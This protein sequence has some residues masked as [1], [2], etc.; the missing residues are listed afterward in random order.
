M[1]AG[2]MSIDG[3]QVMKIF[4]EDKRLNISAAYLRPGFAFGG[5][6][7]PKDLRALN[8]LGRKLD[9][10][11]PVLNHILE[12]N[13]TLI[14][15]GV[16]RILKQAKKKIAFLGVSFKS[17]TDD[18]RESPFVELVERIS[19][20][21]CEVRIFD[22]NVHLAHMVGANKEYLLR[23]LPHIAELLVPEVADAVGW[24]DVVVVTSAN[25]VYA[26][27]LA[28]LRPEQLVLDF[29]HLDAVETGI[30]SRYFHEPQPAL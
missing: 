25:S 20:K 14:E 17:G 27:G 3:H 29:A 1:L 18:V 23:V 22:P 24:A 21:G 11:L 9:L 12:S 7:L 16:D 30:Q 19:G 5:S 2:A 28:R 15:R 8:Y 10:E 4:C 13:R 26:A 6:C